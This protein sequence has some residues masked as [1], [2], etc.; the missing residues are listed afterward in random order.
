MQFVMVVQK[1]VIFMLTI[2]K[3]KYKDDQIF[4]FRPRVNRSINGWFMCDEGRFHIQKKKQ[5]DSSTPIL[6][7]SEVSLNDALASMFKEL[8]THKI[9]LFVLS[10]NLSYEEILN[11]KILLQN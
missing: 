2:E 7:K 5:I 1:G 4:R 11:L 9:F 3:K 6:N 10:P 8:T